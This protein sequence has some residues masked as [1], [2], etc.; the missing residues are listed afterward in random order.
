[1]G[2]PNASR[3][4]A[5]S[6][7]TR[8]GA[9]PSRLEAASKWTRLP[10]LH[11]L[12][13][14]PNAPPTHDLRW[15]PDGQALGPPN[16]SRLGLV[17]N[18]TTTEQG[19]AP[20]LEA[21]SRQLDKGWGRQPFM[22]W[23]GLQPRNPSRLVQMD[24]G[25]GPPNPSRLE[26]ASKYTRAGSPPALHDLGKSP[27]EQGFGDNWTRIGALEAKDP[28]I[29]DRAFRQNIPPMRN[30]NFALGIMFGFG[31]AAFWAFL[32]T[33]RSADPCYAATPLKP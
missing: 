8:V 26:A 16:L 4:G 11:D 12:R 7:S 30:L 29:C 14:S 9:N 17:S 31:L 20:R 24:K 27:T 1:M 21:A 2:A 5:A 28:K 22:T 33:Q 10:T 13:R 19:L 23:A 25:W 6:K 3:H 32:H 18:K 15:P